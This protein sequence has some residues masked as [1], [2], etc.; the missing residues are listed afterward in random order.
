[1]KAETDSLTLWLMGKYTRVRK[2]PDKIFASIFRPRPP[3]YYSDVT[4]ASLDAVSPVKKISKPGTAGEMLDTK[5][6][7]IYPAVFGIFNLIYWY[8]YLSGK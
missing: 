3:R 6:R 7:K 8:T 4:G 5:F 1:M 2:N